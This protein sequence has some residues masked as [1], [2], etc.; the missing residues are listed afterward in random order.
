MTSDGLCGF[1]KFPPGA[2]LPPR[3]HQLYV[4]LFTGLT[5]GSGNWAPGPNC[6]GPGL[7]LNG[8]LLPLRINAPTAQVLNQSLVATLGHPS[9]LVKDNNVRLRSPQHIVPRHVCRASCKALC[10]LC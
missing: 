4:S 7:A 10:L 5:A 3:S 8:A 9:R 2:F 6:T 1:D